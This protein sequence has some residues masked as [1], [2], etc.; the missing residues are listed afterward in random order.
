MIWLA[1]D[2][3]TSDEA[4]GRAR[5]AAY[6]RMSTE[7]QKYSTE[8]QREVIGAYAELRNLDI[9][10]VYADEGKSGLRL[11]GR[12]GLKDL[13]RDVESGRADY[14]FVLVY[15]VSRW[16]RFQDPD[17][18]ASYEIRCKQKGV[19]IL[20]CAEQFENDGSPVSS[21]IKSLKRSMA[22]EYSRELSV[23]VHAGQT[24]LIKIGYRQGGAAGYGLRRAVVD[25]A[26][27][28]T[29]LTAGKHKFAQTDRVIL[30]PGPAQEVA[31]VREIYRAFVEEGRAE[32]EIAHVLN[33]S[34]T[35]TDRGAVWTRGT[36]HQ[37]LI[38]EKY[39]GHNVWNRVSYKLKQE[40]VR[41]PPAEW[42]R[43]DNA[44]EPIVDQIMFDAA[45]QM[46]LAR[47]YRL[48]DADMLDALRR[49]LR[50]HGYLS[51]IVIDETQDCPS[52]SAFR[53]RFGSLL[54]TYSLIGYR[55]DR[56]YRYV[57][58]NRRL[59]E[60]HPEI[61]RKAKE[62]MAASGA[63]VEDD[64]EPGLLWIN[65]EFKASLVLCRCRATPGGGLR[66]IV[67]LDNAL[68]PDLTVAVRME[69]D[70]QAIRD[71]YLLP[72]WGM[73]EAMLRIGEQN[74]R[75]LDAFRFDDLEMLAFMGR[76]APLRGAS[77]G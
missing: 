76:R 4:A 29:E 58:I 26:G 15:D 47:S 45:R 57:E 39:A 49:A 59:R 7:H 2:Q 32:S 64:A 35:R 14:D 71:Y 24:R 60:M 40:R 19:R 68:R 13:L 8:N 65:A 36:V 74:E 22:G 34:G 69:P 50:E 23:K 31:T 10:R 48:S 16:G 21:I 18:S 53:G 3:K 54:R 62:V 75:G 73:G 9:V 6:V 25:P 17:E 44:F 61:V 38:N 72:A 55:P 63:S 30:R 41:N 33:A 20:Y 27:E 70:A 51:G 11:D 28:V 66:W 37:I 1:R 52:S 5:A 56:D 42:V 77:Y 67:R 43:K 12:E 46:I